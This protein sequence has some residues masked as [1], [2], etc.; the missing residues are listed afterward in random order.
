MILF[1]FGFLLCLGFSI[2]T[3]MEL[4]KVE[5]EAIIV[6]SKKIMQL[7]EGTYEVFHDTKRK[8]NGK[9]YTSNLSSDEI[10]ISIKNQKTKEDIFIGPAQKEMIYDTL[11]QRGY[12]FGRIH[13]KEKGS[14][15][16]Q[17][18]VLTDKEQKTVIA[19]G[20]GNFE[21]FFLGIFSLIFSVLGMF[22]FFVLFV[23]FLVL[24]VK[25]K[26][27]ITTQPNE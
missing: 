10:N 17:T 23:L 21:N 26:K 1:S 8:V 24:E 13:I 12:L 2:F 27:Q 11:K 19:I 6:P 7:E 14:Y 3:F 22:L 25:K 4:W 5:S 20:K 15:E 16:I 9:I 18:E